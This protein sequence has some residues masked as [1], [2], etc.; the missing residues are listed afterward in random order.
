M[1]ID[2]GIAINHSDL[3]STGG[4]KQIL[5]RSWQSGD[6]V[7]FDND[8]GKHDITSIVDSGGSTA[9]WFAYEFKNQEASLTVNATKENGSTLFECNLS[10]MLPK[11]GKAKFHELQNLL[12]ECMMAIVIDSNGTQLVIGCSEKYLNGV[13][14]RN[15][16]FLNLV[17][18]EGGTGTAFTDMNGLTINMTARQFELPR[19][20]TGT[21][22][23]YTDATPS[24]TLKCTSN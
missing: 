24:S 4:I 21:L 17:S 10:F 6:D 5:L 3:L 20:Y 22:N 1:A 16:T 7:S 18:M 15:Q 8:A 14:F 11:L 2:K 19:E 13:R 23:F 12:Q 9:N